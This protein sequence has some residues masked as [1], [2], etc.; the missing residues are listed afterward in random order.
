MTGFAI[1]SFSDK[2]TEIAVFVAS[3]CLKLQFYSCK[4]SVTLTNRMDAFLIRHAVAIQKPYCD[5]H[6]HYVST[7]AALKDGCLLNIVQSSTAYLILLLFL[8]AVTQ[9]LFGTSSV[10]SGLCPRIPLAAVSNFCAGIQTIP[11]GVIVFQVS[12]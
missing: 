11:V 1:T 9:E 10:T 7:G 5:A 4:I 3:L 12:R 8:P 6:Y 2:L